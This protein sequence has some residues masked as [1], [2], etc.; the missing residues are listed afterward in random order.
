MAE[1]TSHKKLSVLLI[2]CGKMGSALAQGWLAA[3]ICSDITI[4]DPNGAPDSLMRS[5]L[6]THTTS[7]ELFDLDFDCVLLATKPQIMDDV[8]AGLAP[9]MNRNC[10]ILSIAAGKTIPYFEEYF[11]AI[12]PII[13]TM[14]NTPAAIGKGMTVACPNASVQTDHKTIA[15]RLLQASGKLEWL[16]DENLLDAVTAVSGSGPAY[17]FH[18]IEMMENAA[19]KLG[20]PDNLAAA[21]ARQTVIGSAALAEIESGISPATLRE[22]VTSPGGTTAAALDVLMDPK[23]GLPE[24]MTRAVG[25]AR[26]RSKELAG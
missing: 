12:Q 7:L 22:N 15:T 1:T 13:R 3:D 17:V 9:E 16:E 21:L 8:C 20:L 2:G 4:I 5:P 26:D 25:A 14:P 10:L 6:V 24:L 11:G 23:T 18:L 19:L